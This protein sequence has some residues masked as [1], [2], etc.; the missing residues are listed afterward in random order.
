MQKDYKREQEI[1]RLENKVGELEHRMEQEE[2]ARNQAA[3]YH[4]SALNVTIGGVPQQN[5]EDLKT[6]GSNKVTLTAVNAVAKAGSF[7]DFGL[8]QIDVC[9]RVPARKMDTIPSI[10]VRFRSKNARQNFY[11]Q[12]NKLRNVT[13]SNLFSDIDSEVTLNDANPRSANSIHTQ[14]V[15]SNNTHTQVGSNNSTQVVK[16]KG[17]KIFICKSLTKNRPMSQKSDSEIMRT[18]VMRCKFFKEK[19]SKCAQ[20]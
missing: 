10:V 20:F 4:R 2:M 5:G 11:G 19:W 3:Q 8:D 13:S 9:H 7:T 6:L 1:H 15:G 16:K 14:V 17:E 12:R 18:K